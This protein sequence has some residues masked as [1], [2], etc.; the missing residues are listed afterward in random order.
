MRISQVG[1]E[2]GACLTWPEAI[3]TSFP[4]VFRLASRWLRFGL[5][6]TSVLEGHRRV[7]AGGKG[8]TRLLDSFLRAWQQR[9]GQQG[10]RE[11]GAES[12]TFLPG[13]CQRRPS[14]LVGPRRA[15][16]PLHGMGA[17]RSA[18]FPARCACRIRLWPRR[19]PLAGRMPLLPRARPASHCDCWGPSPAARKSPA[20]APACGWGRGSGLLAHSSGCS[21][22]GEGR[23]A[24]RACVMRLQGAARRPPVPSEPME[25]V[26]S[27]G[28]MASAT[29]A[30]CA[31]GSAIATVS[32]SCA[33]GR[34]SQRI[35]CKTRLCS[36][37]TRV[38]FRACSGACRPL[39]AS[40]PHPMHRAPQPFTPVPLVASV[41]IGQTRPSPN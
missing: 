32:G 10:R 37:A 19:R 4:S 5:Q 25:S 2:R 34:H 14:P 39:A 8:K 12:H 40:P 3:Y 26:G 20:R 22:C 7:V 23:L 16:A 13:E 24:N 38:H 27:L 15:P 33:Y 29:G 17:D 31:C 30:P 9:R 35:D 1:A 41:R 21:E 18:A 36:E 11:S 6:E 28:S